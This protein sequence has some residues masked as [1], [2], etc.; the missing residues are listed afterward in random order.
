MPLEQHYGADEQ[1]QPNQGGDGDT[2]CH[3]AAGWP[4]GR[5]DH[6]ADAAQPQRGH[7]RGHRHHLAPLGDGL[8]QS[9]G[10]L[11]EGTCPRVP[12]VS[13][14]LYPCPS[15]S[16]SPSVPLLSPQCPHFPPPKFPPN[17]PMMSLS[18][19]L[20]PPL[21]T[22]LYVSTRS[23]MFPDA[24]MSPHGVR[25]PLQVPMEVT[26]NHSWGATLQH[27]SVIL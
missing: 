4:R 1:C 7:A 3:T 14:C 15:V 8:L 11:S 27:P 6:S 23:S 9:Q 25:L 18:M 22:S 2:Q 17:I 19:F 20:C 21:L 26:Q 10:H 16:T 13:R 5:H 12:T 24:P